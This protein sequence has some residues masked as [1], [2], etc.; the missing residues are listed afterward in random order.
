MVYRPAR[1][2]VRLLTPGAEA[3]GGVA[4]DVS[5]PV[6]TRGQGI[7]ISAECEYGTHDDAYGKVRGYT[8]HIVWGEAGGKLEFY[9]A[10]ASLRI[11][12]PNM[13]GG[14]QLAVGS[15]EAGKQDAGEAQG[16]GESGY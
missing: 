14:W 7:R 15:Q 10:P 3:H 16:T 4:V 9:P 1:Q 2:P 13:V 12:N 6:A 11:I 5:L 8:V